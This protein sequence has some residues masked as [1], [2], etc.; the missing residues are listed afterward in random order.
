MKPFHVTGWL[1][2]ILI[3]SLI[4][5]QLACTPPPAKV[6]RPNQAPVI[7]NT[8][9]AKDAFANSDVQI[10]CTAK[11]ADGDNLTYKWTAE[12]GEIRG[13]GNN[14]E[15]VPPGKMGNYAIMLLVTDGKG[16]VATENI[17]IRVVTNA[18]GTATPMVELKLKLGD[19]EPVIVDKQRARVWMT[20]A[21]LCTVENAGGSDFSYTWTAT[22][23]KLQG[24]GLEEGKANKVR[25]IAP[26]VKSDV[27]VS[28]TVKDSQ[29]KEAKGQ[30][31]I[32]VFCCG[33]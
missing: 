12:A 8:N 15:W 24:T 9:Y 22:E 10:D 4:G 28:V 21:I 11:D 33:N 17:S 29:G 1:I 30:V 6:N 19:T 20:S 3:L 26:G 7:E 31:N 25:W 14:I 13:T 5:G 23:G 18:D 16:G 32:N 2:A 27:I